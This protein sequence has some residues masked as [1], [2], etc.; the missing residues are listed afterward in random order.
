MSHGPRRRLRGLSM[1]SLVVRRCSGQSV[2]RSL[3][4]PIP[5]ITCWPTAACWRPC[6]WA[7]DGDRLSAVGRP[8]MNLYLT[9]AIGQAH[10]EL[11]AFDDALIRCGVANFN[12]IR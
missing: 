1:R 7:A 11:A 3:N 8:T 5:P 12:L 2:G 6:S 9:A 4:L 10:T